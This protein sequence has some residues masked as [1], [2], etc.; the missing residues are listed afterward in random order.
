MFLEKLSD[1]IV[2]L[3]FFALVLVIVIVG[4]N[5][6]HKRRLLEHQ[7]R[8]LAIEKGLPLPPTLV[9]EQPK[10]RNPYR[11][12]LIWAGLGLGI[13][14]FGIF[15]WKESIM[16]LAAIPLFIGVGLFLANHF[17]QKKLDKKESSLPNSPIPS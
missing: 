12:P 17:Y 6:R 9:E 2:P 7:Q 8:M 5:A 11:T 10:I 1:I 15:K 14:I 3:A 4:I 13:L 16:G